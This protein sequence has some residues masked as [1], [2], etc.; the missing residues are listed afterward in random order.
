MFSKTSK[1]DLPET[2]PRHIAI[3]LD[4]NGRWAAKRGLPRSAGHLAGSENFRKISTFCKNIGIEYLT[5][6]AFSTENWLRPQDE[7]DAIM[8]LFRR[9]LNESIKKME[10]NRVR[11]RVMGDISPV[12]GD[13]RELIDKTQELS[14]K[15][16]GVSLQICIN[17]GSRDE[18]VRA[19][20]RIAET[21]P[22]EITEELISANLDS[23]GIPDPDLCIRPSGEIRLSNFMLWQLAYSE[24]FFTEKY[25]P[26]FKE[27]DLIK[28]LWDY[29]GRSRR[30]G[31]LKQ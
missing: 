14:K 20:R 28:I 27:K 7:I 3:I 24:L 31:G 30:F 9:Y 21:G 13:I 8:N 25:W 11:I 10:Q 18:I 15:Y 6:Y 1:Y 16:D 26:D 17:Y 5:V 23:A 22:A 4:G 12:P 29:S 19:V 2:L